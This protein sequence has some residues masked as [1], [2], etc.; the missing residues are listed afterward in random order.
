[1]TKYEKR[2]KILKNLLQIEYPFYTFEMGLSA[3]TAQIVV[4]GKLSMSVLFDST[5]KELK[6]IIK[7]HMASDY[8]DEC[9]ICCNKCDFTCT[10]TCAKCSNGYCG[11]CYVN[12]FRVGGGVITCPFCKLKIGEKMPPFEVEI[13]VQYIKRK[14][15]DI[16]KKKCCLICG[17]NENDGKLIEAETMN[18]LDNFC[19]YCYTVQ[20]N[21]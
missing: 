6:L 21:M 4:N 15:A 10:I 13:G 1:M 5:I 11:E 18:G 2:C 14:L 7:R 8:P 9:L 3:N 16:G 20:M 17:D 12:L 19:E